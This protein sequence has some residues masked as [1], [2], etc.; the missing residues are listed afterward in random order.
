[1]KGSNK[2]LFVESL[3]GNERKKLC[4]RHFE[5]SG[6]SHH[7]IKFDVGLGSLDPADVVP[8]N[9]TQLGELLLREPLLRP[10]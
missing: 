10:Q 8:V 2:P 1:M 4:W 9:G 3:P 5:P 7:V 6:E